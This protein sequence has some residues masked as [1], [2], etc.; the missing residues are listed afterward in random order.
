[1]EAQDGASSDT[2]ALLFNGCNRRQ[3]TV[4]R[5]VLLRLPMAQRSEGSLD[6]DGFCPSFAFT[7]LP[8][9]C[10]GETTVRLTLTDSPTREMISPRLVEAQTTRPQV[11]RC[12]RGFLPLICPVLS[13][14]PTLLGQSLSRSP[15]AQT[16]HSCL[17]SRSPQC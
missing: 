13:S 7:Q 2:P 16:G 9:F 8:H 15:A 6:F 5:G 10:P 17:V 4:P 12:D 11:L 14:G 1:M 3:F